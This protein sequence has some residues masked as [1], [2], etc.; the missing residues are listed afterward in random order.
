[1]AMDPSGILKHSRATVTEQLSALLQARYVFRCYGFPLEKKERSDT[2]SQTDLK[3]WRE[4][5]AHVKLNISV[6][7]KS[8]E[9]IIFHF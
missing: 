4:F 3:S 6:S 2:N 1:M 5:I 8:K 9:W 7:L